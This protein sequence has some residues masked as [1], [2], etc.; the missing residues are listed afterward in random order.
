VASTLPLL[1]LTKR[2]TPV[3]GV[4][5]SF[6]ST[7]QCN[8]KSVLPLGDPTRFFL[9]DVP[10]GRKKTRTPSYGRGVYQD[11]APSRGEGVEPNNRGESE[12]DII[13]IYSE[14]APPRPPVPHS[15]MYTG[16]SVIGFPPMYDIRD[17]S[18]DPA[19]SGSLPVPPLLNHVSVYTTYAP[20]PRPC[21]SRSHTLRSFGFCHV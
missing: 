3:R 5:D 7:K 8:L 11:S 16:A 4:F 17:T 10:T 18:S 6:G 12:D 9:T 19:P 20:S 15:R 2:P 1:R 13:D 21:S 14:S